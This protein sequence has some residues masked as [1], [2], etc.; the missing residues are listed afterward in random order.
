MARIR[1]PSLF[2]EAEAEQQVEQECAIL[3]AITPFF[4]SNPVLAASLSK[5]YYLHRDPAASL[6]SSPGCEPLPKVFIVA[7]LSPYPAAILMKAKVITSQIISYLIIAPKHLFLLISLFIC[8]N[9]ILYCRGYWSLFQHFSL[10]AMLS[11]RSSA[12]R[13][14]KRRRTRRQ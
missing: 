3:R 13:S 4:P 8:V 5:L 9:N 6:P 12:T 1:F 11:L 2:N 10:F 14:E 7:L